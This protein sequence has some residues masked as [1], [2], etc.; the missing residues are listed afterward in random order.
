MRMRDRLIFSAASRSLPVVNPSLMDGPEAA[1]TVAVLN[2]VNAAHHGTYLLV[3]RL[4][5]GIQSGAWLIE[6]DAGRQAVLKW[7]PGR[8]WGE[9]IQRASR[10][11]AVVRRHGYPTPAW[12]AVGV[13]GSG[14]GY[15]V[16][17]YAPGRPREYLT[18]ETAGRVVDLLELQ[19]DLDPD[20]GRSWSE[21]VSSKFR[22]EWTSTISE[23]SAT[24]V[25]GVELAGHA[26]RLLSR[27]EVPVFPSTDLVHGDF[28]L[29]NILFDGE[30]I[31]GVIDIE[32]L[33]SGTRVFDY[34]T[35]LD[36]DHDLADDTAVE[37]LVAAG[38]EVAGPA[39]LA[40]CLVHVV[41]DLALFMHRSRLPAVTHQADRRIAALSTRV[42]F[43]S[44]LLT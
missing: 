26:A 29:G 4:H 1:S 42:L 25:A 33:G 36:Q 17:E 3:R 20:P 9:Q 30:T 2:E 39:V 22:D 11:V 43:V 41:L 37:L 38:S 15:Q 21:Y 31:S 28:R 18:E 14:G 16:Q 35:L 44:R 13:T 23:V 40:Y 24:G 8:T 12:L 6:D 5:G 32:A 7:S 34:A 19:R 10:A 27:Y